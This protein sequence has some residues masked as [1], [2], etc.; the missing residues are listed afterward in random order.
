MIQFEFNNKEYLMADNAN[1]LSLYQVIE[2]FKL[3]E[4][5]KK[6]SIG[7]EMHAIQALDI[8]TKTTD[9]FL[10]ISYNKLVNLIPY[11]RE[12][13][14][15]LNNLNIPTITQQKTWTID[16]K[17]FSHR[18]NED[19]PM[20]EVVDI[21]EL[22]SNKVND[23]D[24]FYDISSIIIKPAIECLSEA[25]NKYLKLIGDKVDYNSNKELI[26]KNIKYVDI[27]ATANFFLNGLPKSISNS[28]D[29]LKIKKVV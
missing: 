22:Y 26:S 14:D 17:L 18:F 8:L 29:S 12:V 2:I 6:F 20:G 25:G 11:I 28:K 9:E 5:T 27:V 1:E 16:G 4:R 15:G 3:E 7:E 23:W 21:K 13:F 10:E 19:I 24:Y